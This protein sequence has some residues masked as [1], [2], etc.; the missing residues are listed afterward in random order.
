MFLLRGEME[1][2]KLLQRLRL[3]LVRLAIKVD[4]VGSKPPNLT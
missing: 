4:E 3:K 1:A 2:K